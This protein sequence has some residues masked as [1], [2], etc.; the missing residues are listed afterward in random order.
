M[1]D[2]GAARDMDAPPPGLGRLRVGVD[3]VA[4]S[5]VRR[6]VAAHGERY[7]TRVF[8]EHELRSCDAGGQPRFDSLAARFAA[9]EAA[10]KA[11]EPRDVGLDWRDVE[12]RRLDSGAC[13]LRLH[14]AA[15]ELAADAGVHRLAVS[16]TH[17]GDMA[18]AVVIAWSP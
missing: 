4:V 17:E 7:L 16:M 11:L 12:V 10:V 8:T 3:L 5:E 18:A 2:G 9:K 14:G 13:T 15:A 1:C 6:A